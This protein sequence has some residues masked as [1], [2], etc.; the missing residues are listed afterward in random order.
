MPPG[1]SGGVGG[2]SVFPPDIL[3]SILKIIDADSTAVEH[4]DLPHLVNFESDDFHVAHAKKI[5]RK[6]TN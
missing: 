2:T 6:K 3:S 1:P 4:N 5:F